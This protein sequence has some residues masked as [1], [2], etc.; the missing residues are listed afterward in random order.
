[1]RVAIVHDYLNQFGGAERVL[2]ALLEIFPHAPVFT[3]VHNKASMPINFDE[4]RIKTS[5][6]QRLPG[7]R[8]YHRYFPLLMP[9]A[10]EQF[11][12]REYDVVFSATHSFGKGVIV[13]PHTLHISYCFTPTRYIWDDSHKYVR[14]FSQN[15]FFQRLAPLAL[16]YIRLWDY[17][18]SQRVQTYVT[19]SHYVARRIKKYYR[20]DA[21]VIPPP[22]DVKRFFVRQGHEG[23]YVL[24]SRL[25]PYKRI[26]LAIE[27]CERLGRRL[28]IAGVGPEE[29]DL[30]KKAGKYTEFLGFVPDADLP[31]LYAGAKALLFPQEEDFGITPLEAAASGKPTIAY[32]AGGAL[33]TI[34]DG[35]T[36]LFFD[37]QDA[38][39][40]LRAMEMSEKLYWHGPTIRAHAQ[41]Y[42]REVF[43]RRISDLV[44]DQWDTFKLKTTTL[45]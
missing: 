34:I 41:A 15:D 6:L 36:G 35:T 28:K 14:E 43:L 3:L 24:V 26:N 30:K 22:V 5:F 23:Y 37:T 38:D 25:M 10:V 11:D 16:S 45:N 31:A 8:R 44:H 9:L 12:F 39:S 13:G 7:A 27:A 21:I 17:Y 19:L 20:R 1:M 4:R 40:L 18:A 42:G 2:G 29:K 33:E 32:R